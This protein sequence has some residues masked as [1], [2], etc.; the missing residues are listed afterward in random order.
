MLQRV[1]SAVSAVFVVALGTGLSACTETPQAVGDPAN[2]ELP[3]VTLDWVG[4]YAG[5]ASGT[6]DGVDFQSRPVDML[7]V[8]DHAPAPRC[9]ACVTVRLMTYFDKANLAPQTAIAATWT[10]ESEGFR[11]T[12]RLQK[13]TAGSGPGGLLLGDIL[14]EQLRPDGMYDVVLSANLALERVV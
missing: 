10:Y 11:R 8:F 14:V 12:L 2:V 13:F 1:V 6:D 7:I 9:P 4:F 5:T 3:P